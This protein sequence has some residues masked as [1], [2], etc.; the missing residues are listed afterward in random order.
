MIFGCMDS[1]VP[2]ERKPH[3]LFDISTL[4]RYRMIKSDEGCHLFRRYTCSCKQHI[5]THPR[6]HT[7]LKELV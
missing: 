5:C 4:D 1:F 7:I 3:T 6:N 2:L